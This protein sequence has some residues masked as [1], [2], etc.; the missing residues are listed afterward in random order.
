[1]LEETGEI[2][3]KGNLWLAIAGQSS[4][5]MT[6]EGD[7][8]DTLGTQGEGRQMPSA[9][10][11]VPLLGWGPTEG[12]TAHPCGWGR[13]EVVLRRNWEHGCKTL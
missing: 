6:G 3:I 5:T 1:M 4:I 9:G 7:T 11:E 2:F 13:G 12:R 8:K 10:K